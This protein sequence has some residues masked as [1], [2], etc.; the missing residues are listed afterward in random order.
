[1]FSNISKDIQRYYNSTAVNKCYFVWKDLPSLIA[2][3]VYRYGHWPSCFHSKILRIFLYA[4]Y[5]FP[6]IAVRLLTGIQ[7][8]KS[9]KIGAGL[10][11]HHWGFMILNGGVEIG[12]NCTL[13]PGVVIGNL[14]GGNDVPVLGNNVEIGVGAKI[15]GKIHIGNDVRIGANAVVIRDVPATATAVG[16]PARNHIVS[17]KEH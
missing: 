17:L 14:H 12:N 11:I 2:I 3:L 9:C 15:L 13:R 8:P 16:V 10:R 1:M 5:F 7:I 6:V 4:F